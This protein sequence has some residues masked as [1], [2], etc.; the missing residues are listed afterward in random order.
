[1]VFPRQNSPLIGG[2][3]SDDDPRPISFRVKNAF[4]ARLEPFAARTAPVFKRV[5]FYLAVYIDNNMLLSTSH[6]FP[7][8]TTV[9]FSF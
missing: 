9:I 2:S 6:S 3:P 7:I 8:V 5:V 4:A 1:M